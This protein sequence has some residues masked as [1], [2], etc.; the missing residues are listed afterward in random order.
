MSCV[1]SGTCGPYINS[2]HTPAPGP[3]GDYNDQ[4]PTA[5]RVQMRKT[6]VALK[7]AVGGGIVLALMYVASVAGAEPETVA[8]RTVHYQAT[9]RGYATVVPK[10]QI[11][12]RAGLDGTLQGFN[13]SAGQAVSAGETIGRIGGPDAEATVAK[14]RAA[15]AAAE[16]ELT[17]AQDTEQ[18]VAHLFP[19]YTDRAHFDEAKAALARAEDKAAEAKSE[20]DRVTALTTITSPADGRIVR[21]QAALGDRVA[22]HQALLQIDPTHALWVEAVFYKYGAK[23]FEN[24]ASLQFVPADGGA[25][26]PLH[27]AATLPQVREDGG[28]TFSFTAPDD[29]VWR[30]GE[31]GEVL[32]TAQVEEAV[33]VPTDALILDQGRW[34]VMVSQ[35]GKVNPVSVT[36]GPSRGNDTIILSG[37]AAGTPVIVRDA[38]LRFHSRFSDLYTAPD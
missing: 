32:A 34:W 10:Q 31:T 14:A 16:K 33:A 15:L 5:G 2:G 7:R 17:V 27:L 9:A 20:V 29:A 37:I 11:T 26:I 12:V 21:L 22:E 18:S 24:A 25:A 30:S 19:K 36:P 1:D 4:R 3:T 6:G 38:Y 35:G 23:S 28:T 13:V 8:A